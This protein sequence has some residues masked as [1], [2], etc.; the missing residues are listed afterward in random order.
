MFKGIGIYF[1]NLEHVF[2]RMYLSR[3]YCCMCMCYLRMV[4]D[5]VNNDKTIGGTYFFFYRGKMQGS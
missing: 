5:K 3:H 1:F 2:I 4:N